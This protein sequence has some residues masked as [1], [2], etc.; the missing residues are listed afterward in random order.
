MRLRKNRIQGIEALVLAILCHWI[1]S[2]EI[3]IF[4]VCIGVLMLTTKE[5][6]KIWK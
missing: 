4:M 5:D 3:A 1:N 2:D 6:V